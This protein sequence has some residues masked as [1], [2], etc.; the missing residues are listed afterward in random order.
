MIKLFI[1]IKLFI[2]GAGKHHK[3]VQYNTNGTNGTIGTQGE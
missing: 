2:G 3:R 1:T